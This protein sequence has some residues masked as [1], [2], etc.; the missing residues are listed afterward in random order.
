M[1]SP[2]IDFISIYTLGAAKLS[3]RCQEIVKNAC[4]ENP[5]DLD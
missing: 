2:Q 1:D 5:Y 3:G 4:E